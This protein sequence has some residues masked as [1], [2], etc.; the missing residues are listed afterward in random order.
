VENLLANMV[1]CGKV[2]RSD[3]LQVESISR[4]ENVAHRQ[5]ATLPS[6]R[7]ADVISFACAGPMGHESA[8]LSSV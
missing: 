6:L 1:G 5:E 2:L 4:S 3:S 8:T 7:S